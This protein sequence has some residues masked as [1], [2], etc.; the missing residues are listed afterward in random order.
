MLGLA[1]PTLLLGY[2]EW[3]ISFQSR[4]SAA[5]NASLRTTTIQPAKCACTGIIG[6]ALQV[7]KEHQEHQEYPKAVIG[8]TGEEP[9]ST[10]L[11]ALLTRSKV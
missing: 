5:R 7:V 3:S 6:R 4:T 1:R 2:V 10:G 8:S 9:R 11:S